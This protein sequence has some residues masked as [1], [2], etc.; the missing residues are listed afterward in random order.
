MST[1]CSLQNSWANKFLH[2][3]DK[4]GIEPLTPKPHP[5]FQCSGGDQIALCHL[6]F[7]LISSAPIFL[8]HAGLHFKKLTLLITFWRTKTQNDS[9]INNTIKLFRWVT[10]RFDWSQVE[11][12]ESELGSFYGN[13][14]NLG[15]KSLEEHVLILTVCKIPCCYLWSL[16]HYGWH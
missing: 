7:Y 1:K 14:S 6:I 15:C 3:A 13:S 8:S 12:L 11:M 5:N 9:V 16:P 10:F 2:R 4:C